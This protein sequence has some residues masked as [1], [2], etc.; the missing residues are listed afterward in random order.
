MKN[1]LEQRRAEILDKYISDNN[2][3]R[4]QF[5]KQCGKSAPFITALIND[6]SKSFG[7]K[8]AKDLEDKF[9]IDL[10]TNLE[11]M[12]YESTSDVNIY[13][14][15]VSA[16][17]GCSV[18]FEPRAQKLSI[19]DT[20]LKK[21]SPNKNDY[22]YAE[23][24]GLSMYDTLNE[25]D[26]VLVC[27]KFEK[28]KNGLIYV[29]CYDNEIFVKRYREEEGKIYLDSDNKAKQYAPKLIESEFHKDFKIIGR[30]VAKHSEL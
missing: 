8:I 11:V 25:G 2:L 16:G 3:T 12:I 14:L 1:A 15:K 7:E 17:N 23:V 13:D 9:D 10:L 28:P 27:T 6:N 26:F 22:F 20:I 21:H 29:F 30:V 24:Y 18:E 5:A 19:P 4:G